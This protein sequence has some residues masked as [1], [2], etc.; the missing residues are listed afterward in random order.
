M[1][2]IHVE[3]ENCELVSKTAESFSS[4]VFN[5]FIVCD[6]QQEEKSGASPQ[7]AVQY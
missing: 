1:N 6:G 2:L 3:N 4:V 5:H 7:W